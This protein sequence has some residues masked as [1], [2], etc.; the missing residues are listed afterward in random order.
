MINL[1]II[2]S[3]FGIFCPKNVYIRHLNV[4]LE[5]WTA[6]LFKTD[7][8]REKKKVVAELIRMC[9]TSHGGS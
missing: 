2:T 1:K 4:S 7:R 5:K 8:E 6:L 3:L 9:G